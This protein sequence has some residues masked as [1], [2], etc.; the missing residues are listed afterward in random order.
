[1]YNATELLS[2]LAGLI[3]WRQNPD[4]SGDQLL[5]L[6]SSASG[7]YFNDQH[8]LLTFNNLK[9]IAPDVSLY[10]YPA[11]SGATS[12]AVGD[13]VSNGGTLYRATA[14]SLNQEPPNASYWKVFDPFTDWLE[15]KTNAGI[16][17]VVDDWLGRK[18]E[19]KT[20]RNLL[21]RK[22]VFN[23]APSSD[24][25]DDDLDDLVGMEFVPASSRDLVVTIEQIGLRFSGPTTVTV[26]LFSSA[27]PTPL[28]TKVV[29]YPGGEQW[30][31]VNWELPGGAVY[32]VCYDQ[33]ALA[34]QSVN[35]VRSY[36]AKDVGGTRFPA[37]RRVTMTAFR[38]DA[39]AAAL[40]NP[41]D[42]AYTFSTNYGLNFRMGVKC[43]YT[44]FLIEQRYTLKAL[45]AMG[46]AME[47]L[48]E[49][50]YNPQSRVNRHESNFGITQILYEIDG[51]SQGRP[52]GLRLAYER[53]MET[54]HFDTE[55]LDREC[56][57]CRKR[58]VK[59]R[60]I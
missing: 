18:F 29:T 3:G 32:Y 12:Y 34:V 55:G 31:E 16:L 60:T 19:L 17:K 52:G 38:V 39:S 48:R 45:L 27:S 1:M 30:E 10:A 21:S 14:I 53:A 8:P 35:G 41:D 25:L 24:D 5:G 15:M 50:A 47:F 6:T 23:T 43:D 11:W 37:I 7:L 49:L 9:S 42:N 46:V 4:P 58:A 13:E 36:T 22:Q 44:G 26:Y 57:P 56:L 2:S 40:W 51:D 28:Q 20:A 33:G 59:Y 54:A